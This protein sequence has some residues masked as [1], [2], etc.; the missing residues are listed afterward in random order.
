MARAILFHVYMCVILARFDFTALF[1]T[2]T[3]SSSLVYLFTAC[4]VD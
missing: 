1:E 4:K 2:I 3:G